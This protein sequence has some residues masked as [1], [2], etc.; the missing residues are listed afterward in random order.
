MF[1]Q[2]SGVSGRNIKD[3][4]K[5]GSFTVQM[6]HNLTSL[7]TPPRSITKKQ[8]INKQVDTEK[9]NKKQF[10]LLAHTPFFGQ[11]YLLCMC[12]DNSQR[13]REREW[14]S[15]REYRSETEEKTALLIVFQKKVAKVCMFE[16]NVTS[17]KSQPLCVGEAN[18]QDN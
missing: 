11:Q 8:S 3:L 14:C 5:L 18:N 13:K 9:K 15:M 10:H 12:E 17:C 2:F 4:H 16:L 6:L 7:E 1:I